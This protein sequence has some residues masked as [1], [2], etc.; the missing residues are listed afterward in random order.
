MSAQ[1]VPSSA[2]TQLLRVREGFVLHQALHA[3]AKLGMKTAA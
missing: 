3:V 2:P 1:V